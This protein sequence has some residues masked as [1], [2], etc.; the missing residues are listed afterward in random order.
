MDSIVF[1]N[2]IPLELA[3][4]AHAGT[5]HTPDVRG[6]QERASYA[7]QLRADFEY[8]REQAEKGGTVHLLDGEFARY[9]EGLAQ[10]TRSYLTARSRCLSPLVTG[11]SN[12][13][14]SRNRKR[15]RAADNKSDELR[16]FRRRAHTAILRALRPDIQPIRAGDPDALERL[17]E[18]LAGL[19]E[20]QRQM[21]AVNAAIRGHRKGGIEA[22]LAAL[23]ALNI[24]KSQAE[25]LLEPD[26]MGE[27]G[28]AGY[29]LSLNSASI[30][31]VK[32][33]IEDVT[34][35]RNQS[36]TDVSGTAARLEDD[37]PA[38]RVR[39]FFPSKPATA[40]IA[41]LKSNAFR[42]TPSLG[43]WQAYR[44]QHSIALARQLA[45][46]NDA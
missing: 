7:S 44:N 38:N 42:W 28:F 11:P 3:T 9:R 17:K 5:S 33:Q 32:R 16:D 26:V 27:I 29:Q 22:Q 18:K 31:R 35:A 10:R 36:V 13:P 46:V 19:E 20:S 45:G 8:F 41:T 15:N 24:P 39:L 30:R 12:F 25:V 2:D 43:A 37:P 40:V 1:E 21:K 34:R 6:H 4:A 23:M 14:T